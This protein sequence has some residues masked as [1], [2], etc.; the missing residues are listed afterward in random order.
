MYL[1]IV[2]APSLIVTGPLFWLLME[3]ADSSTSFGD[4]WSSI[5]GTLWWLFPARLDIDVVGQGKK[6][7]NSIDSVGYANAT[8]L[9]FPGPIVPVVIPGL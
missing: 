6:T 2:L 5:G 4:E 9:K 1:P 7:S 3:W 8:H